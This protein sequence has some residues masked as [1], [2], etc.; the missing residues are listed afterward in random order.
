MIHEGAIKTVPPNACWLGH[1]N[2]PIA[3]CCTCNYL[4]TKFGGNT[5]V[6]VLH[7]LSI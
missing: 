1:V 7:A 2:T 5:N 6:N 3:H 4:Y